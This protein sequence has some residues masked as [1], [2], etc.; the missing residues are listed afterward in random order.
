[1]RLQCL[2]L[3]L[4]L[5]GCATTQ[6]VVLN[7]QCPASA[8]AELPTLASAPKDGEVNPSYGLWI[9]GDVQPYLDTLRSR[10]AETKS[11]CDKR[12]GK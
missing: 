8:T 2:V 3:V 6:E 11:W 12:K 9:V 4:L 10:I 5:S 1:M 7:D